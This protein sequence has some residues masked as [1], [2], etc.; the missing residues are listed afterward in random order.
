MKRLRRYLLKR[1]YIRGHRTITLHLLSAHQQAGTKQ[2]SDIFSTTLW[3]CGNEKL[4]T[5]RRP[6]RSGANSLNYRRIQ[7]DH[8]PSKEGLHRAASG[9]HVK[10]V[11]LL[12]QHVSFSKPSCSGVPFTSSAAEGGSI[13]IMEILLAL[14][15]ELYPAALRIAASH[16]HLPLAEYIICK[17]PEDVNFYANR[18]PLHCAAANGHA[19][20]VQVLLRHS[21]DHELEDDREATPLDLANYCRHDGVIN[22]LADLSITDHPY[23]QPPSLWNEGCPRSP[24]LFCSPLVALQA[25]LMYNKL[26][27]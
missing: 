16:G 7:A 19:N 23:D 18:T 15:A 12:C 4:F 22:I 24:A 5:L 8:G 6:V 10:I 17:R 13:E 26:V 3:T 1:A 25:Y 14:G 21:A 20:M 2:S 11:E 9:G 27:H